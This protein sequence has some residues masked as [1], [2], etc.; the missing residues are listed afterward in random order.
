MKKYTNFLLTLLAIIISVNSMQSQDEVDP[1]TLDNKIM[2]G[3]QGWFAASGDGAGYG[4]IHWS[5]GATPDADNI[6]IDLWPDMREYDADELFETNFVYPDLTNAGLYSA[7]TKKTV[8]RHVKWM[9]DYGIDGVFVQRFLGSTARRRD[10]RDTVLQNVRYAAEKYGRVF[11]NM[12][13]ISGGDANTMVEWIKNDWMHLVD[14]LKITE[15]PNYLNHNGRPVLSIWGFG[16]AD[17]PGTPA[18]ADEIVQWLT[19]DAPGKYLVT[20]KAGVNNTW[21]SHSAEWQAVYEK[22]DIISPWAVGRYDDNTGADNFRATYIEPDLATTKSKN[23]DYMPVVFPGFSWYNLK[24]GTSPLNK[25]PRNGGKFLWHQFYNAV[26]AGCNMIYVAMYDEV[27]EGTAIYKLAEN[28]NQIPT[29]GKFVTLDIDGYKIP[30]DWYL[31]LTG[32]ASKMLRGDIPLTSG[33]PIVAY[34]N[35]AEFISQNVPT[36]MEPGASASVSIT[37]KNTGTTTWTKAEKYMLVYTV[38]P[39]S[40]TWGTSQVEMVDN[41]TAVPGGSKDFNFTITAPTAPGVYKFQWGLIQDSGVYFDDPSEIRLINVT[42]NPD[43][44]DACDAL[45]DWTS[46]GSLVLNTNYHQQGTGCIEYIGNK[47][48]NT[49]F[50]KIFTTPYN[51]GAAAYDA[52]LQFWYYISGASVSGNGIEVNLGSA[53]MAGQDTYTW[54]YNE[55]T[56]GWNLITL[57]ADKAI[58]TG[59]PDL[60]A[61][62]WFSFANAKTGDITSRIDEIQLFDKNSGATKYALLVNN[63]RGSGHYIEDAL[64]KIS[65]DESPD[66][67]DFVGWKVNA[68][69]L[70]FENAKAKTTT[71]RILNTDVEIT[72]EYKVYGVYL[73]DCDNLS[74]WGSSGGLELNTSD[75]Q[76]GSACIEFSGNNTDE[77]KKSFPSP[78]NSGASVA[79]GRLKLWYYVSDAS[80][81]GTNN[82]LELGSGGKADQYEY[83]WKMSGLKDGWNFISVNFSDARI[84]N[85]APDLGAINWFRIYNFKSGSVTTR[86]DAIEI[87]DPNAGTKYPLT[88]RNGEGDGSYYSGIV[89]NISADPAPVGLIFYKWVIESGNPIIADD[90]ASATTLTMGTGS[91]VIAASYNPVSTSVVIHEDTG[92]SI[93]IYPNPAK[94][95]ISVAITVNEPSEIT[96][97]LLDLTGRLTGKSIYSLHLNPGNGVVKIPVSAIKTGMYILNYSINGKPDSRLVIIQK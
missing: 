47:D 96:V 40:N 86:I 83:N 5:N 51:S 45:S 35:S 81:L 36:I 55:L 25:R 57:H 62:N 41:E 9:K 71:V 63:G 79:S 1:T 58:V 17:R 14:D 91:T 87:V 4:W 67:H 18:I 60:N 6:T 80:L 16:F 37:F 82:Q 77:F 7:Y 21:Q 75:E 69:N 12:Y 50:E 27:D 20:L 70:L 44:L 90:S 74:G 43:Y 34:P 92:Y 89:I 48:N 65:A 46:S 2:A 3:Y 54:T 56:T 61:I 68:G 78:F 31:R 10:L 64:V 73:D 72:A 52:V 85:Y 59:S 13:D 32:E 19:V 29:S 30:G 53:G 66:G 26:D 11:T 39:V 88:I 24:E 23:I 15:S 28:K 33:I 94:T 8:E 38:D 49:E 95:E 97:S 84:T 22:F 42:S 76:E 93:N